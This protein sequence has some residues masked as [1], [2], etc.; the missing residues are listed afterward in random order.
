M[1]M[2]LQ[3]NKIV[4]IACKTAN[5]VSSLNVLNGIT[6]KVMTFVNM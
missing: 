3:K 5:I 1:K 2:F 6:L 4:Y